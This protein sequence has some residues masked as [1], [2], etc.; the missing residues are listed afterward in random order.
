MTEQL[1]APLQETDWKPRTYILGATIGTLFGFLA[2]YLYARA[3]EDDAGGRGSKPARIGTGEM[4]GLV[5]SGLGLIR[6]IS[7]MGKPPKKK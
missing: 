6:Q 5:L 1:P 4:L 7:E 3:A 2:A